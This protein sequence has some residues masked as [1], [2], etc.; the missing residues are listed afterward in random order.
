MFFVMIISII[1]SAATLSRML[2]DY[3]PERLQSAFVLIAAVALIMG[4]LGL[5]GLEPRQRNAPAVEHRYSLGDTYR[6]VRSN[7]QVTLF[8]VYL[9]L[10]LA[11][12]LGQDVLLEPFAA[13][14]FNLPVDQTTR[15]TSIWG[16]SYLVSLLAAGML[17]GRVSKLSVARLASMAAVV[18]FALVAVSGLVGSQGLFYT[19][20]V[21]LGLATGPATVSNLSL[22]LDMTMPGKVGLFIGAWGSASA[23]ARLLGSL[24]TAIVR[25]LARFLPDQAVLGYAAGFSLLGLFLIVSLYILNRVD[26]A[27]FQ[28]GAA[29]PVAAPVVS[30]VDRVIL[31]NDGS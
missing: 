8:F 2:E 25:D 23:F 28:S 22:M 21:L 31:A 11:A 12:V 3:T 27:A 7:P 10:M 26:L 14:A 4:L 13:R 24:S 29:K 17:E 1:I 18:A 16:T 30:A 6:E 5:I 9:M 15:I 20:L 19:G